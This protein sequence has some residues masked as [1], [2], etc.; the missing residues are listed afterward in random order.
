MENFLAPACALMS[1]HD[2]TQVPPSWGSQELARYYSCHGR[3]LDVHL[4]SSRGPATATA[5]GSGHAGDQP[6]NTG[7]AFIS[8]GK[9]QEADAAIADALSR[10]P[11]FTLPGAFC[12]LEVG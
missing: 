3:V 11:G 4:L 8:Y 6:H 1:C 12:A 10:G 2:T 7:L 5:A 9:R